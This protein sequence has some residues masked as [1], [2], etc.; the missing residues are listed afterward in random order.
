MNAERALAEILFSKLHNTSPL[1]A[2]RV[3]RLVTASAT[4]TKPYV[5][6]FHVSGGRDLVRARVRGARGTVSVKGVSETLAAA[7]QI[8]DAIT[9]LLADSGDQDWNP[10]LAGHASWRVLT[11]TEG[12]HIYI[13]EK[14]L[15]ATSIYHMGHQYEYVMEEEA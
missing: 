6:F 14:A 10:R 4:M 15:G 5:V 13:E 3:E 9:G 11:L 1:W 12:R 8:C 2:T 7:D